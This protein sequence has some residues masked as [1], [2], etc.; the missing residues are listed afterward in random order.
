MAIGRSLSPGG[1]YGRIQAVITWV[2]DH[3]QH[4]DSWCC[5]RNID[6]ISLPAYRMHNLALL[7]IKEDMSEENL[8]LL[9]QKL[10]ECDTIEPPIMMLRVIG[11]KLVA[12]RTRSRGGKTVPVPTSAEDRHSYVPPW[13]RGDQVNAN[14]ALN[15][16]RGV[17][18]LP[19]MG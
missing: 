3:W 4:F 15:T 9:E 5:A 1:S 16:M 2:Q 17:S 10:L 11:N 6:P 12:A 13:W 19:K 7:V 18:S 14:V 8:A